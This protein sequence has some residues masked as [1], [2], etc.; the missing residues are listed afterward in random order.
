ME[1]TLTIINW[2]VTAVQ[3][4]S[5]FMYM[6]TRVPKRRMILSGIGASCVLL[7]SAISTLRGETGMAVIYLFMFVFIAFM[8]YDDRK[9]YLHYKI[10]GD[11]PEED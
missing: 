8:Y 6:S 9:K 3:L 7:Y 11:Q 4:I 10:H 5:A 1:L 2:T